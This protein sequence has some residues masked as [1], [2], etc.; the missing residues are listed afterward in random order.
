MGGV[1]FF[2]IDTVGE[3]PQLHPSPP[4]AK[5]E[6]F[7]AGAAMPRLTWGRGPQSAAIDGSDCARFSSSIAVNAYGW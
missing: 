5:A 7:K 4:A 6:P 2:T 3:L 1:S